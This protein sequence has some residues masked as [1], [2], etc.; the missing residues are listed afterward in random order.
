MEP[1]SVHQ[2][3]VCRE[4]GTTAVFQLAEAPV[5]VKASAAAKLLTDS[6]DEEPL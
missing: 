1:T 6:F 2:R 3:D 5:R 4:D